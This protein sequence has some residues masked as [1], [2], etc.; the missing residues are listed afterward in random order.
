M[1]FVMVSSETVGV[2]WRDRL[3]PGGW[4]AFYP[5]GVRLPG[6]VPGG[7]PG[8]SIE[9]IFVI[10]EATRHHACAALPMFA[11]IGDQNGLAVTMTCMAV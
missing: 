2:L 8:A 3:E 5:G 4:P 6:R 1:L 11:G 9:P 7:I 10:A